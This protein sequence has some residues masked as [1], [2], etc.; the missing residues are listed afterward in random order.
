M[1]SKQDTNHVESMFYGALSFKIMVLLEEDN[2][3]KNGYHLLVIVQQVHLVVEVNIQT[4][5]LKNRSQFIFQH[6]SDRH[7]IIRVHVTKV[8]TSTYRDFAL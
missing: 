4:Q 2:S 7:L 3:I 1:T 8:V 5:Y 6:V